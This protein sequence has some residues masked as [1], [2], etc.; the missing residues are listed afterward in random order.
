M[1]KALVFYLYGTRNAGDMAICVGAIELLRAQGYDITMVS[2]FSE[3]EDEYQISKNYITEYYPDVKISPGPFSFERSFSKLKKL[4]AYGSS[5]LTVFGIRKNENIRKLIEQA[6]VV[7]FNGGN[8][9]RGSSLADYLRLIALFYPIEIAKKT[10]KPVYCLPQSTAAIST[11]GDK[12]LHKYLKCFD[13]IFIREAISFKTLKDRYSDLS[14]VLSTD[15]A[16]LCRDTKIAADK[17]N[18]QFQIGK[19]QKVA[20]IFRNTGIGDIGRVGRKTEEKLTEVILEFVRSNSDYEYWVIIQTQKDRDMSERFINRVKKISNIRMVESHDPLLLREIYKHMEFT[21][22]MRLHAAILSL[23]AG[24]P[25]YGVF[26]NEWGLKNPGIM[27][28]YKM[29]YI[30]VEEQNENLYVKGEAEIEKDMIKKKIDENV[31][32]LMNIL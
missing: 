11:I 8:L 24:T 29:D 9:L 16:F 27:D 31:L 19:K 1:K 26:S 20:L 15:L 21:I 22:S 2:R 28:A 7:F 14:F 4:I 17:F 18:R 32:L 3:A 5:C 30:I 13:K 12:I 10:G 23:S 6:D 25:V